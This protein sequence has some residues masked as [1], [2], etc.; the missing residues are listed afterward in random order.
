VKVRCNVRV[1]Y[2]SVAGIATTLLIVGLFLSGCGASA[3]DI[4]NSQ[5]EL[6]KQPT[7]ADLLF[8]SVV[9]E[10]EARGLKVRLSSREHLV[11]ASHFDAINSELRQRVIA[12]VIVFPRGIALNV[13][14]EYQ[15]LDRSTRPPAWISADDDMTKRRSKRDEAELGKSI[16]A[17]FKERR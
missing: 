14:S 4:R 7:E 15:R 9:E 11:N 6:A 10:F 1:H 12:R 2:R 13:T 17:R 16:Q 8:D 3:E 5:A